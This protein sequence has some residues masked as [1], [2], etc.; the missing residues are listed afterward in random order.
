MLPELLECLL[1]EPYFGQPAP[2][3]TGRDLFHADWLKTRLD[4]AASGEPRDVQATL[5]ELTATTVARACREFRADEVF[6]CG[7][8]AR[9]LLLMARLATLCSPASVASTDALG[10]ASQAVEAVAFAW[11]AARRL[12]G[13]AGNLPE[14]TGARGPRVLGALYPA[15]RG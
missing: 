15:P 1:R 9:N 4:A 8:G 14:V 5:A 12:R 7:G 2:K 6:V 10:A 13:Q 11:L 3:S